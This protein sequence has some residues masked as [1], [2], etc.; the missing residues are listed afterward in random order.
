MRGL[1]KGAWGG[2]IRQGTLGLAALDKALEIEP[3]GMAEC[4]LLKARLYDIAGAKNLASHEYRVF[5]KKV[6]DYS[7]KKTLETYIKDNPE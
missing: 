3:V 4:H 5:L 1:E 6:P 7:D 2:L